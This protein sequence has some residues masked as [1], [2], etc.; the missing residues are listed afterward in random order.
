M[1]TSVRKVGIP[2]DTQTKHLQNANILE[3]LPSEP[4]V[5]LSLNTFMKKIDHLF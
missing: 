5:K 4:D 3:S 1:N 2:A